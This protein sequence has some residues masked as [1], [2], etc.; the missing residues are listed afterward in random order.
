MNLKLL[1]AAAW[2]FGYYSRFKEHFSFLMASEAEK[3]Y[4]AFQEQVTRTIY[5]DNLSPQVTEVV[6][7]SALDQYGCVTKI[8]FIPNYLEPKITACRA[9][10]E[11]ENAKQA[12]N[13][14]DELTAYPFQMSGMPRPVRVQPAKEEMFDDRPAKP[15][16][17]IR[18]CWVSPD[19][20]DFKVAQK[21]KVLAKKHQAEA[22]LLLKHQLEEEENLSKTQDETLKSTYQ[23]YEMMNSVLKEKTSRL[24]EYYSKRYKETMLK[25]SLLVTSR[26]FPVP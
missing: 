11:L 14:I 9:L 19:D 5:L 7:R 13:I 15:G 1:A 10:V 25:R 4:A 17:K 2:S 20:P 16:R 3:E 8:M 12:T 22:T 21:L 18:I 6:I 23:K 24:S 26:G